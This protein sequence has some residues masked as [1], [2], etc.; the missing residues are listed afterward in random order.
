[1]FAL[2]IFNCAYGK[3]L[4]TESGDT[5]I[6]Y[7]LRSFLFGESGDTDILYSYSH[8]LKWFLRVNVK[9]CS[10]SNSV[11]FFVCGST[12]YF[13]VLFC[14]LL[15]LCP[16]VSLSNLQIVFVQVFF[17]MELEGHKLTSS[18]LFCQLDLPNLLA[19][20]GSNRKFSLRM[21]F[22]GKIWEEMYCCTCLFSTLMKA[23]ILRWKLYKDYL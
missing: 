12:D 5:D 21:K 4:L 3:I 16:V 23:F 18:L 19:L 13:V 14:P 15:I 9:W 17:L 6:L 10:W 20:A 11:F 7:K 8:H 2:L 1:M 22:Q